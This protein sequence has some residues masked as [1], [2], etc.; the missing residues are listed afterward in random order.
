MRGEQPRHFRIQLHLGDALDRRILQDF[1]NR[2]AVAAAH[3]QN[4]TRA[5]KRG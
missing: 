4:A 3:H 5:R 1:P 2:E